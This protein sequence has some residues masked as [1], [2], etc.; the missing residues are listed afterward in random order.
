MAFAIILFEIKWV[1]NNDTYILGLFPTLVIFELL[2]TNPK[3]GV[4]SVLEKLGG[5]YSLFIYIVH[6][7]VLDV[8]WMFFYK[9]SVPRIPGMIVI[10]PLV[11]VITLGVGVGYKKLRNG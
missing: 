8:V 11:V 5:K 9:W 2:I 4:G 6:P 10:I 3:A 1:G 7:I